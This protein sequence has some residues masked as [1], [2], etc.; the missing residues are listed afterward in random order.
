MYANV[1]RAHRGGNTPFDTVTSLQYTSL[2]D[3]TSMLWSIDTC[4]NKVSADQYHVTI[5]RARVRPYRG[6]LF[7]WSWPL[8]RD[9]L[10]IGSQAQGKS[11]THTHT[12]TR[13]N[14]SRSF[15]GSTRLHSHSTSTKALDSRCFSC[16][17]TVWKIYFS[18]IFCWFQSR[19]NII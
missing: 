19:F 17:G 14:F 10:L 12:W 11:D 13:L 3:W 5:S 2:T 9:W 1:T 8:T 16:S 15:C 7:F 6:Q 18:C 4:Q